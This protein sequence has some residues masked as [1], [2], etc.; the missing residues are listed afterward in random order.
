MSEVRACAGGVK[1]ER[2][3]SPP[4]GPRSITTLICAYD[5]RPLYVA[6]S[7]NANVAPAATALGS[8]TRELR[9][10]PVELTLG[11]LRSI[12]TPS[13]DNAVVVH[14]SVMSSV[15]SGCVVP[16]AGRKARPERTRR[17]FG[18]CLASTSGSTS[19]CGRMPASTATATV[20]LDVSAEFC[21]PTITLKEYLP[22]GS[23]PAATTH[24]QVEVEGGVIVQAAGG[25]GGAAVPLSEAAVLG[26]SARMHCQRKVRGV[27]GSS[28]SVDAHALTEKSLSSPVVRSP[29]AISP[30]SG[31]SRRPMFVVAEPHTTVVPV[32]MQPVTESVYITPGVRVEPTTSKSRKILVRASRVSV[33]GTVP[34][35]A[36]ESSADA[37]FC[38][39]KLTLVSL[40]TKH[41]AIRAAA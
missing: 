16:S 9:R 8:S 19:T 25:G 23:V 34:A 5:G 37:V 38:H 2:R 13:G 28:G 17:L 12:G 21:L 4:Y 6:M 30:R 3:T 31:W 29:P 40:E 20:E 26:S 18:F 7:R 41:D 14:C 1:P 35:G 27:F 10:S 24:S 32:F 11:E 22:G 33:S 36:S 39:V 15:T